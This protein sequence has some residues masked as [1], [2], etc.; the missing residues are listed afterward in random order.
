M[1]SGL[2]GLVHEIMGQTTK[3]N[4]APRAAA[5]AAQATEGLLTEVA[6]ATVQT[7]EN[8]NMAAAG[9]ELSYAIQ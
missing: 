2:G 5:D 1:S 6:S 4:H 3:L 8:V 7:P 9:E